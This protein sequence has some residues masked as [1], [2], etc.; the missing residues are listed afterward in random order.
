ML[1]F[2]EFKKEYYIESLT[3]PNELY[4]LY[5]NSKE[6]ST[7][8]GDYAEVG[9]Y[10]GASAKAIAMGKQYNT[11]HLFDTFSGMPNKISDNDESIYKEG[12]HTGSL[13]K[14]KYNLVEFNNIVYHIGTVP[15]TFSEIEKG[16]K[17]SFV[18]LDA[19]IYAS[20]YESLMF[21]YPRLVKGGKIIL[22]DREASGVKAAINDFFGF[23]E[24]GIQFIVNKKW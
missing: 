5:V 10:N 8:N 3:E 7:L 2:E 6:C 17:F 12:V 20:T 24:E 21:F 23:K 15:D 18:N 1:D 16:T 22:H 14:T 11:L 9:V 4:I 13:Q 19:D